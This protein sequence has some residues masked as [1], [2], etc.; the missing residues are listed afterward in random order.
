MKNKQPIKKNIIFIVY[1]LLGIAS[2]A[3]NRMVGKQTGLIKMF[4]VEIMANGVNGILSICMVASLVGMIITD[5]KRGFVIGNIFIFFSLFSIIINIILTNN[6][7]SVAGVAL[8]IGTFG[9][10]VIINHSLKNIEKNEAKLYDLSCTDPMTNLPNRRAVDKYIKELI[11]SETP[12]VIAFVDIDNFKNINDTMGHDCGDQLLCSIVDR[13]NIIKGNDFIAR[14]GG[15]EFV[16]I[17]TMPNVNANS[18]ADVDIYIKKYLYSVS[19]R[20]IIRNKE[21]YGS[22]SIGVTSYP[23]GT[24]DI[25]ELYRFADAAM[26]NAKKNGRN[27]I[28]IFDNSMMEILEEHVN[29]E[30]KVRDALEY[31]KFELVFQ[32]Q[33]KANSKKLRGFETLLRLKDENGIYI[34]PL[35]F[36]K[37]A[38]NANLIS[39]VDFWVLDNAT[40][41]F[42]FVLDKYDKNLC[43]AINF[44]S[45]HLLEE[46]FVEDVL[47][48][49]EKNN[50]P[51]SN[52]EIEITESV[53]ISSLDK[54][55]DV[56]FKLK[57]H[58][59][60]VALD[61]FGTGY[62]TLSYLSQLPID[63]LKID[64]SFIDRI[65]VGPEGE[66]FVQVIIAIGHLFEY[67]VISEGVE[68]GEQLEILR[69]LG[70][71]YIQG[72][73]WGRPMNI[74]KVEKE[75]L[76]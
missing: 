21:Y 35:V 28:S 11:S 40:K 61:D 1:L 57:E 63:L 4:G 50:F 8:M 27:R 17:V 49:L 34:S 31:D 62:A 26:Y 38:E 42:K 68:Y 46:N 60:Q 69:N 65:N 18:E 41:V 70:C 64:K 73:Y 48:I 44:S 25:G 9:I 37:V 3:V 76:Q 47:A 72:Y 29:V 30:S 74:E 53:F 2:I 39:K 6:Y 24:K 52:L 67:K 58:G 33:F 59:I 23:N 75:L 16:I 43:L 10:V 55:R 45:N 54:A 14:Q 15:D 32:P 66:K 22:A 13:W 71:D 36:I 7:D 51:S 19:E 12:F 20:M 56:I 5:R